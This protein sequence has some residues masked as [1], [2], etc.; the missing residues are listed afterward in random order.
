MKIGILDIGV[1]N[2]GSIKNMLTKI[3]VSYEILRETKSF[4]CVSKLILP[5][6]GSFAVN[7]QILQTLS[8]L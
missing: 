4:N 8:N 5:G 1:G 6:V 7:S 2:I 3:G